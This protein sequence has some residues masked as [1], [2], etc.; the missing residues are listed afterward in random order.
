MDTDGVRRQQYAVHYFP[1]FSVWAIPVLLLP[2][3]QC[4]Y[5]LRAV[6]GAG[7]ECFLGCGLHFQSPHSIHFAPSK[8]SC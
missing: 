2:G 6:L 3:M 8:I 7:V 5:P 4:S 1:M